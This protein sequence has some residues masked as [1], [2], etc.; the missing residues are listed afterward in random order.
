VSER[1]QGTLLVVI[2]L[3]AFRLVLTGTY[4]SYVRAGMR[5]P[6]LA[7]SAFLAVLGITTSVRAS[8]QED[9][10]EHQHH[11]DH[12]H[13]PWV[14][15]ALVLPLGVLLL[16]APLPLGA[17]AA[18]RQEAFAP[19][20][21]AST[22][23]PLPE[24]TEGAVELRIGEIVN[25]AFWDESGAVHET[26]IRAIGFVTY[27]ADVDDGFVLTRFRINCCAA[28]AIPAKIAVLEGGRPPED[29]WVEVVGEVAPVAEI[30]PDATDLP[31][32][33]LV[34]SSVT[35]ISE[36]GNPYE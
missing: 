10:D 13:R 14:G 25:R 4:D 33:E 30:D 2:G 6:L 5:W 27:A 34:A 8:V 3:V 36:P 29:R 24:P 23:P 28:D 31:R 12:G 18:A 16:I 9:T 11:D 32:V 17:D 15:W 21:E 35:E 7:A 19:R 1:T 20:Y 26:P 22:F